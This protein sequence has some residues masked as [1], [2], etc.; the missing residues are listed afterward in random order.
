MHAKSKG[1]TV[2]LEHK[3]SEPAM[4]ILMRNIGM[5]LHRHPHPRGRRG[6]T[7]SQVNMDWQH[8]IMNGENLAEYAALLAGDGLARPSA[9]QLRLGHLRRRQHGRRHRLHGNHRAR[10]RAR[11]A[12]L[13][14]TTANGSASTST[15]TPKTPSPPSNAPSSTGTSSTRSPPNSTDPRSAKPNKTK[16]P[17]TP[18]SSSTPHS[19]RRPSV[20]RAPHELREL[21]LGVRGRYVVPGVG[22]DRDL[23]RRR[24]RVV[25][26]EDRR[27]AA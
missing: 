9:R 6:S 17:S 22:I 21:A 10:H 26:G 4:K 19:A 25:R 27:R 5:T 13:R 16:T 20:S 15:P 2:F 14:P 8:L 1:V 7:T 24:D 23:L 11:S 3:N 18:T 12:R